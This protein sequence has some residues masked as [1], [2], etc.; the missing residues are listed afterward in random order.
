[1][2][3]TIIIAIITTAISYV[4]AVTLLGYLL[5]NYLGGSFSCCPKI[6]LEKYE[7]KCE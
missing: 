5:S 7:C 2:R 4:L 6:N 1:M 3:K